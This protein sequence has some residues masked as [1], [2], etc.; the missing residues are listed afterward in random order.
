MGAPEPCLMRANRSGAHDLTGLPVDTRD[1][2]GT[3][4]CLIVS[5]AASSERLH[6]TEKGCGQL[7]NTHSSEGMGIH[8]LNIA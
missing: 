3:N 7:L 2:Y 5:T 6:K 4:L 1:I 8:S